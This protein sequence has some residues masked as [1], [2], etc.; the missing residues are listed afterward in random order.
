VSRFELGASSAVGGLLFSYHVERSFG[1]LQAERSL[2]G[3]LRLIIGK[4]K[5]DRRL[6]ETA[7]GPVLSGPGLIEQVKG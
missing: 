2:Y 3:D 7:A 6:H 4:L 1:G 5:K